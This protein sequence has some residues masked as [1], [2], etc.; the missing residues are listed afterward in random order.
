MDVCVPAWVAG[1]AVA[2]L[3][4]PRLAEQLLSDSEG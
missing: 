1:V 3:A 2:A 4:A